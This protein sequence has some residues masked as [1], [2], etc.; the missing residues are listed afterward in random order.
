MSKPGG[1]CEAI[2]EEQEAC[3]ICWH[4]SVIVQ[5]SEACL[6]SAADDAEHIAVHRHGSVQRAAHA[7][8]ICCTAHSHAQ[9]GMARLQH[10]M[11]DNC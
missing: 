10:A 1:G 7:A 6:G 2:W 9:A 8:H 11:Q 4:G 5:A 3:R